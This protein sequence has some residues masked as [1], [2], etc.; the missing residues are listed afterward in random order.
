[1]KRTL[2]PAALL[3]G[4]CLMGTLPVGAA[5]NKDLD[6]QLAYQKVLTTYS[7]IQGF[8]SGSSKDDNGAR[9]DLFDIDGDGSPELFISPDNSHANGVMVYTCYRGK[10]RLLQCGEY[11]AFGSFGLAAVNAQEH[12]LGAFYIGSGIVRQAYYKVEN[13]TLRELDTFM[14]DYESYPESERNKAVWEHNG[15]SVSREEYEAAYAQYEGL[16]WREDIGRQYAFSDRSPLAS[17]HRSVSDSRPA[18]MKI[19][20]IGGTIAAVIIAVIAAIVSKF[21]R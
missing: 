4:V 2:L 9:W 19:A 3:A 12:M 16:V 11:Q 6:W 17:E 7:R 15:Q 13:G 1:M 8:Q 10:P 21:M 5:K 20:L 14:N 18:N